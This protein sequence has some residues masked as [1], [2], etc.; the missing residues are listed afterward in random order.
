MKHST[1][2]VILIS[3][4]LS[5]GCTTLTPKDYGMRRVQIE[6]A[7]YYCGPRE[8]VVPP[9]VP[10]EVASDPEFPLY[11]QFL[12]LPDRYLGPNEPPTPVVCITPAQWPDWLTMRTQWNEGWPVTPET[13]EKQAARR[14]AGL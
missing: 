4:L 3:A 13:A 9:V 6:G 5:V 2:F 1:T 12:N 11:K 14:A 10:Q 7:N 8:S